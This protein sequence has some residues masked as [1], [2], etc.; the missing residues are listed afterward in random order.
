MGV[1]STFEK[2]WSKISIWKAENHFCGIKRIF[3]VRQVF[4]PPLLGQIKRNPLRISSHYSR[5]EAQF[6]CY[7]VIQK[8]QNQYKKMRLCVKLDDPS[9]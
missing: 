6:Q 1:A 9:Y 8:V 7:Q 4:S 5:D 2:R 3:Y